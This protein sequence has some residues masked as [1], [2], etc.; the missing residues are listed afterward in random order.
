MVVFVTMYVTNFIEV[1][2][3]KRGVFLLEG[4]CFHGI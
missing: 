4:V 1:Q 3:L 2:Q